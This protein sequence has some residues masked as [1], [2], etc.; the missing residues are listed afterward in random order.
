MFRRIGRNYDRAIR[1]TYYAREKAA[2]DALGKNNDPAFAVRPFRP[3]FG[4]HFIR[5][6]FY[7]VQ[8]SIS[9]VLMLLGMYFNGAILFAIL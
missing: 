2:V 5:S 9:Y 8:F 4:Q 6:T 3:S 1:R 7:F